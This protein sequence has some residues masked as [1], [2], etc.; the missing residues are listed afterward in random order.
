MQ[1]LHWRYNFNT[2][3]FDFVENNPHQH[4]EP[5]LK[6]VHVPT[7]VIDINLVKTQELQQYV[8]DVLDRALASQIKFDLTG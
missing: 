5:L 6:H 7:L 8:I 3:E 1:D 4:Y 2:A